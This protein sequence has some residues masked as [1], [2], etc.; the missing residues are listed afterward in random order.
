M[1]IITVMAAVMVG[2]LSSITYVRYAASRS[3]GRP[4]PL[5]ST[6]LALFPLWADVTF[7]TGWIVSSFTLV[8]ML[9]IWVGVA[10][11]CGATVLPFEVMRRRHNRQVRG[12]ALTP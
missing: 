8:L 7:T 10:A 6:R 3:P 2:A 5:F 12:R 9:P 4:I 1:Q 11:C